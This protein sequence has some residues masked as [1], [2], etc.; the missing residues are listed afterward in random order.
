MIHPRMKETTQLV[1][2]DP[3]CFF[4]HWSVICPSVDV[5]SPLSARSRYENENPEK[6][7]GNRLKIGPEFP[8]CREVPQHIN[9]TIGGRQLTTE[10]S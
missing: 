9:T 7:E 5:S 3:N 8:T 6:H 2:V 4:M 10:K 1:R